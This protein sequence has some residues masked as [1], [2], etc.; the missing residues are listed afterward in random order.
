MTMLHQDKPDLDDT[1]LE[2]FGIKGMRWGVRKAPAAG[3]GFTLKPG[4]STGEVRVARRN[5]RAV[6][7]A[8]M[9]EKAK[10]VVGKSSME[11][12]HEKKLT[13]LMHPDRS[14][15]ARLTRGETAALAILGQPAL[16]G[17]TQ[18]NSRLIESRQREGYQKPGT[19]RARVRLVGG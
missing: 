15:A 16:I 13:F 4:R 1:L 12:V 18:L 17:V 14:T 5:V 2:H 10:F 8:S 7:R 3:R 11:K 9:K 6:G 19:N